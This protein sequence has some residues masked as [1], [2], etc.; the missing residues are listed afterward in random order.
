[1]TQKAHPHATH[2]K[3][4]ALPADL[5]AAAALVAELAADATAKREAVKPLHTAVLEAETAATTADAKQ[6]DAEEALLRG[7]RAYHAPEPAKAEPE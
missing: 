3:A 7:A 1:M 4:S 2:A 5:A 6:K